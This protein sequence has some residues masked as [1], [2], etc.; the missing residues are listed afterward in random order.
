M[1]LPI[2]VIGGYLGAGKTSLVNHLLR[3][4]DGLRLAVLVNEFGALPIDEDLIEATD[5]DIISIAGGCV[6]CSY[7][8]DLT[9]GLVKMAEREPLPD[10]ILLEAS[11]VAIPGAIAASLSLL[12]GFSL[13]GILVLVNAETIREQ[14]EDTYVGDTVQRQL[15]DADLVVLNKCDL[16]S[17]S[18]LAAVRSWLDQHCP[19]SG[20]VDAEHGAVP[21]EVV[22]QG[23]VRELRSGLANPTVA[24]HAFETRAFE[25]QSPVDAETLGHALADP[26][27]GIVRSK[28][29]VKDEQGGLIEIQTVGRRWDCR[30]AE[31]SK[32]P[33]LV[34]IGPGARIDV[35]AVE[36]AIAAAYI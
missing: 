25:M 36:Q 16:V 19:A 28:G 11:G 23:L 10:Q 8:S 7:G 17:E 6:C 32:T 29:F 13:D 18:E 33:G 24:S 27:L 9:L 31:E 34:V 20:L 12:Q 35:A 21:R 3:H 22:L 30:P 5:D 15:A 4:A 26:A 14:A 1:T 2:T